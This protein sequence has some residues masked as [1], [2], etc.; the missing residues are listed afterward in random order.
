MRGLKPPPV[1]CLMHSDAESHSLLAGRGCPCADYIPM[2]TKRCRIP[3][4]MLRIPGVEVAMMIRKGHENSCACLLV[5]C[6][7]LVGIPIEQRPLRAELFVTEARCR[8]VMI[9]VILVLPL[10]LNVDIPCVPV[11]CLGHA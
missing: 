11:S 10:P 8:P 2:R 9:E 4:M 1:P 7:Q 6:D 5:A 3:R